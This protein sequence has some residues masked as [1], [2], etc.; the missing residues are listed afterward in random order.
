MCLA[1][2]AAG[3]AVG[4]LGAVSVSVSEL[5][6]ALRENQTQSK[7][8]TK[9]QVLELLKAEQAR[10]KNIVMTNGCFDV[11]HPGHTT[12]LE[13]AKALGDY[14][15]V[16]VNSDNS[17]KQ[18][19]GNARPIHPLL[20]RM[21]WLASLSSVDWVIPFEEETPLALIE[22]LRPNIL[23]K[24]GDYSTEQVV[25]SRE[26]SAYGGKVV[27]LPFVPGY[28]STAIIEQIRRGV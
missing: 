22:A 6:Q 23:V 11:L 16:A 2:L 24:G 7:I 12:Y 26:V 19:K 4:K 27:I 1:N 3:I 15:L 28:S 5:H 8:V 13:Q 25:G 17:V 10:G 9:T 20:H 21:M 18:L 14:L